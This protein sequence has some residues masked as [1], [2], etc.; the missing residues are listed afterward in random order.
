M[1]IKT[2]YEFD[3]KIEKEIEKSVT[4]TEEDR[5][6]ITKTKVKEL[7]PV[8]FAFKKASRGERES[9]EEYRAAAWS[10]AIEKNIMPEIVALKKYNDYL[11]SEDQEKEYINVIAEMEIKRKQL[12]V[13]SVDKE[14]ITDEILKLGEKISIFEKQREAFFQNTAEAKARTKAIEWLMLNLSFYKE[15]VDKPW[16]QFFKGPNLLEK[17]QYSEKLEDA[18]NEL[19]LKAKDKLMFLAAIFLSL[20]NNFNKEEIEEFMK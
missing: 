17:Y 20:G 9:C 15:S 1:D 14:K 8:Y 13:E 7:V 4:T 18:E 12:E 11:T 5:E 3:V 16:E 2:I 6:I 19:Y 10:K